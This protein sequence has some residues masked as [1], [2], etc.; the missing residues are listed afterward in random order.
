MCFILF[1]QV[2]PKVLI[3]CSFIIYVVMDVITALWQS[4][5]EEK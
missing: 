2:F 4:T 5:N 1:P 3:K